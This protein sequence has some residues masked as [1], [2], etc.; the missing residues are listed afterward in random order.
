VQQTFAGIYPVMT[1]EFARAAEDRVRQRVSD[2]RLADTV[3]R[4]ILLPWDPIT[5]L[6]ETVWNRR[7]PHLNG[8]NGGSPDDG[9][10]SGD[11][12]GHGN[13]QKGV[14]EPCEIS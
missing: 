8:P 9:I 13:S 7:F 1:E 5:R 3:V 14:E 4:L 11:V 6:L 12:P 2:G 10:Q